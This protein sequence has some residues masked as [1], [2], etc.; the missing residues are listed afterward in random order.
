MKKPALG[1]RKLVKARNA[2]SETARKQA[3]LSWLEGKVFAA[4]R[5]CALNPR[6]TPLGLLE[7]LEVQTNMWWAQEGIFNHAFS[8]ADHRFKGQDL[9]VT[10]A[11]WDKGTNDLHTHLHWIRETCSSGRRVL[12]LDVS[13]V[14]PLTPHSF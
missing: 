13:G 4:H 3:A 2:L 7:E 14:G 9:P 11:I 8:F 12:V 1:W 6:T 10:I 5:P